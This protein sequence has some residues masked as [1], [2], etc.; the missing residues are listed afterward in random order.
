[1]TLSRPGGGWRGEQ[2]EETRLTGNKTTTDDQEKKGRTMDD[3]QAPEMSSR[4]G[5][6]REGK[7]PERRERERARVFPFVHQV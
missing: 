3:S 7:R 4:K 2:Q 1:M 5:M 6:K